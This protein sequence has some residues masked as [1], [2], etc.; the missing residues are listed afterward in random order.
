[1]P[2]VFK[3]LLGKSLVHR[4]PKDEGPSEIGLPTNV[5]HTVHVGKNEAGDLEGL[6]ESWQS[7]ID[8]FLSKDEQKQNPDAAI[9]A[10]KLFNYSM[11]KPNQNVPFKP[12]I[13]QDTINEELEEIN[14]ILDSKVS[15]K[16]T[17]PVPPEVPAN[18]NKVKQQTKED[19]EPPAAPPTSLVPAPE[20][21]VPP[22][23]PD[24]VGHR[25][26][27]NGT[28][29]SPMVRKRTVEKPK[30]SNA[31]V[32]EALR[33]ICAPGD[34]RERF[35]F[36]KELGAGASGIV[37]LATERATGRRVAIKDIDL[38]KQPRR[39][40]ILTEIRVMRDVHHPNLVNF[41]DAH[42]VGEHLYVVMELLEGGPLTD[43]V[44]ETVL[45]ESQIAAVVKEV[46][47]GLQFLHSLGIVHRD[48]KSDNIL[49]GKDGSVKI[50]DFGFCANIQGDEKRQ[51]MV[52]TPYW[53]APE[54][55]TRKKY[56]KKVDIW[57]LGI[58]AIE[59]ITG[60]PPYLNEAPLRALYLIATHGKPEISSEYTVSD[61][62][63]SFLDACL[64]VEVDNRASAEDLLA[65]SFLTIAG[66]VSA[67]KK[68]ITAA[69]KIKMKQI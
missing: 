10:L 5:T 28:A 8:R 69:Q 58:M 47:Q 49:L 35:A 64:E 27:G 14:H 45:K 44:M 51:T 60:E 59:M 54:V 13:T 36:D 15:L 21:D 6:P 23:I 39:D 22:P 41:L 34:P 32:N 9:N 4:R 57:S 29:P 33:E 67:L 55:V 24:K 68:N 25:G 50:T 62:F 12:F 52:G 43:V 56:G 26:E 38:T 66:D 1:M 20:D 61:L 46:L 2:Q 42:L 40:L 37:N 17:A 16:S 30:M 7:F 48:I 31:A 18:L 53:M 19:D 65:H 11:K 3:S 63:R